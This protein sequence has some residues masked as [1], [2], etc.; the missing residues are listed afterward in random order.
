[1]TK[2]RS[3]L[4]FTSITL[5]LLIF[6]SCRS[7]KYLE[8]DQALVTD[9]DLIGITNELKEQSSLYI[10]NE[11]RPNSAL[12][13][14]M[15]NIFNTRNGKYKTEN[16]R[17]VGEAPHILDSSLVELSASQ[18]Q[19]FLTTK[20]YFNA[21]VNTRI[22][23]NRKKAQLDF[24]ANL[25]NPYFLAK[26]DYEFQDTVIKRIYEMDVLPSTQIKIGEKYDAAKL[27]QERER[28]YIAVK[29]KGY[30]DYVRQ[31]M[32]VGVDTNRMGDQVDLT[33]QVLSPENDRHRT[34]K[35]NNV[36]LVI[37]PTSDEM[38]REV[39]AYHDSSINVDFIDETGRFRLRPISRYMYLR[40]GQTYSLSNENL[41]YDRL[42]EMNGFRSV[43]I[44][45]EKVDSS[46]LD[47]KYELIPRALMANQVEGEYTFSSGMSGF[48]VGN[49]FS[50]RNIFGGAELLEVKLRYG[51]LFDPRLEGNLS[52]KIFN[53]DFQV[54]VNLVVPRLL[55]PFQISGIG[56][57]GLPRTTFSSSLQLFDQDNT[58]S[59]RY[60]INTLN[61]SWWQSP[62]LQHSY[63]PIVLEYRVGKFN[64]NFKE[65]L[66][67]E[68][69]N[70]YVESNDREY[71]GLGSQYAVTWNAPQLLKLE[72][73]S[74]IR[75]SLDLSGNI[76]GAVSNAFDFQRNED[77]Q[78][79][80]FN[81]PYLQYIKGEVDYRLYKHL[82]GNRQV[83]FRFNGGL[84][85]PYGNNSELLIFEKSFFSGGMNGIR[86]WQARTLGP[87]NY[88][89]AGITDENLRLSL[90]NLD[91]L[92]EVKLETNLEY[93]FR[94][95][96]N[97]LGA[98][99]NGATFVDMGNIW[100][101]REDRFNPNGQFEINKLFSQIA[102]GTGFGLRFDMDYFIMRL[103]AGLKVKDPQ[104]VGTDQWVI[105]KIFDAKDFKQEYYNSNRPDRYNFIQYNFGVGLPF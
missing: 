105:Q 24:N 17:Q 70:L 63:T 56:K 44:N 26:I 47:V 18:I 23:I 90:R 85:L 37:R 46:L 21:S 97:F 5:L 4:I 34:Y 16:I 100:R 40:K 84:A 74:F 79:M 25:G 12:N 45:F 93:R 103:D 81:V 10:S 60:L 82:G 49:T 22:G 43:K 66:I 39:K 65:N 71:F 88:N 31:Y 35:I 50:H 36:S 101:L 58:Y 33:V 64:D 61:Y 30:Y 52:Q 92:G 86:A 42:Y 104:F 14:T 20:G 80:L 78:R 67:K 28:L 6:T 99:M 11:I 9:I 89:R 19:S 54:G 1:M 62:N 2:N 95:L 98:K 102:I 76:L 41:S 53:N 3:F 91:Q 38:K 59:N 96:N 27:L 8:A 73:F 7:A 55:L 83:V 68:G 75:G 29:N 13:L 57:Y 72:N 48:N 32:R 15:Y 77:N 94:L 51:V 69:Y 87:G